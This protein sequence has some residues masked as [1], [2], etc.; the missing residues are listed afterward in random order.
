MQMFF[1]KF[2]QFFH[3][4]GPRVIAKFILVF[5]HWQ[6]NS[7]RFFI[8]DCFVASATALATPLSNGEGTIKSAVGFLT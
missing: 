6:I 7:Q 2:G 1:L 4:F 5:L 3:L 8:Q